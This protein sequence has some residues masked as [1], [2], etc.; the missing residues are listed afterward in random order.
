MRLRKSSTDWSETNHSISDSIMAYFQAVIHSST[1]T[2]C[3]HAYR[4]AVIKI[5]MLLSFAC[6]R[7]LNALHRRRQA[8]HDITGDQRDHAKFLRSQIAGQP[9]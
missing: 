4:E 8:P 3:G 2:I 6:D 1:E 7:H 5:K 9:V